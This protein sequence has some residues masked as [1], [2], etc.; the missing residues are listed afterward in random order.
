MIALAGVKYHYVTLITM[1]SK[2]TGV[3]SKKSKTSSAQAPPE[4]TVTAP[5]IHTPSRAATTILQRL[6]HTLR[7]SLDRFVQSRPWQA[8]L[9]VCALCTV[10]GF[11]IVMRPSLAVEATEPFDP[12]QP[13]STRFLA[14]NESA[15]SLYNVTG[16]CNG[17]I[18]RFTKTKVTEGIDAMTGFRDEI[19]SVGPGETFTV[20][21]LRAWAGDYGMVGP[22]PLPEGQGLLS[23][24]IVIRIHYRPPLLSWLR[25]YEARFVTERDNRGMF[26]WLPQPLSERPTQ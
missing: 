7:V 24:D 14:K 10:V 5:S 26:H 11:V 17:E 25:L 9:I 4:G 20:Q 2:R 22:P 23:V 13:H 3:K 21:C 1:T 16:S 15:Y 18:A 6:I 19:P 8:I 12:T